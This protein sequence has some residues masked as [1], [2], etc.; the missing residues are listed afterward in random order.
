[1]GLAVTVT[2]IENV[3]SASSYVLG[4]SPSIGGLVYS[5]I[6]VNFELKLGLDWL[7]VKDTAAVNSLC[8]SYGLF[9]AASTTLCP[10]TLA[11]TR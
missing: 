3:I 11:Q 9:S 1:M 4:S 7:A 8:L 6:P 10:S 2:T 5:G